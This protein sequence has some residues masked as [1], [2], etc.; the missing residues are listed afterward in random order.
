M[1]ETANSVLAHFSF[2]DP[3]PGLPNAC[4]PSIPGYWGCRIDAAK[5]GLQRFLLEDLRI[6]R[7]EIAQVALEDVYTPIGRC[8]ADSTALKSSSAAELQ[9]IPEDLG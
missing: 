8:I 6:K 1:E 9:E 7:E 3:I 4:P 5:E 2:R